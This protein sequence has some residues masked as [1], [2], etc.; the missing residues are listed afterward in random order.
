MTVIQSLTH[1]RVLLLTA[2]YFLMACGSYGFELWLP[3]IVKSLSGASNFRVTL[4]TAIP[5]LVGTFVMVWVAHH[6]DRTGE[7][8]WHVALSALVAGVGFS[9]GAY[10]K[11]PVLALGALTVA[12]AGVKALHGP[13]WALPPAFLSGTGAAAG[14]ALINSVGN[15]GGLVG[16]WV[17]GALRKGTDSFTAGLWVSGALLFVMAF[18]SLKIPRRISGPQA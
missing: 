11:N 9:A 18:A 1:P 7:R 4:L 13:F 15:L 5:Y 8:R 10:L 12:W 16:P 14:I 3:E 17:A 6:S 2:L